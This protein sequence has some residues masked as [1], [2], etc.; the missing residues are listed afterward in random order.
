MFDK[1]KQLAELKKM[2]DSAVRIQKQLKEERVEMNENGVKVV[3]TG[4]QRI[5]T[6][7]IDG[8]LNNRVVEVINKALKKSQEIAA[9]KMQEMS[10]GLTGLL[11]GLGK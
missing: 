4:D 10:G 6:L 1:L 8:T 2:R 3:V 11:K 9:K 7:E 5:E